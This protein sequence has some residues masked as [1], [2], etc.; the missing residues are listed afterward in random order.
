[1]DRLDYLGGDDCRDWADSSETVAEAAGDR[2][3]YL[4]AGRPRE[5]VLSG[6]LL[7]G[8][9]AW[10]AITFTLGILLFMP[11]W[12]RRNQN[13]WDKVS[14]TYVVSDPNDVWSTKPVFH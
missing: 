14:N 8:I 3:R 7:G 1:M 6:G 11:F 9:V 5:D 4:A 13:L 12:D 2:R 10:L